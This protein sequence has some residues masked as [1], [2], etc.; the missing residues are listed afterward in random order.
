[1]L[2]FMKSSHRPISDTWCNAMLKKRRNKNNFI[3][4]EKAGLRFEKRI[5]ARTSTSF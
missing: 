5:N 2:F 1:M 3:N 4:L